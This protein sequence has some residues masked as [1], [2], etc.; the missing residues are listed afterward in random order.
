M[1]KNYLFGSLFLLYSWFG[2]TQTCDLSIIV[3]AQNLSG[4]AISQVHIYEEFQ[5]IVTL[6]NTGNTVANV[7]FSQEIDPNV[8]VLSYESQNA[9]GG[10]S[11]VTNFNFN[12]TTLTGTVASLPTNASVQVKIVMKAS[13]LLG[14]IATIAEIFPPTTATDVNTSNNQS[15]ISIDVTDLP[16]D[17]TVTNAQIIPPEGTGISNWNETVTYEFTITNN[18]SIAFP[19]NS[20]TGYLNLTSDSLYG[21][22]LVQFQSLTCV[23]ATGGVVCPD[24]SNMSSTIMGILVP[25]SIFSFNE[26]IEFPSGASIT[27]QVEYTYLEPNCALEVDTI[28]VDSY[29]QIQINHA[30]ESSNTSNLV[31]TN[32]LE[33]TL[34][35]Q[36]DLCIETTQ[37]NPPV[38]QTINWGEPVTFVTTVCNNGPLGAN[39]SFYFANASLADWNIISVT[40]DSTTGSI[41]CSDFTLTIAGNQWNS[42]EFFL[43]ENTT[44]TITTIVVFLEPE[45]CMPQLED[46]YIGIVNSE[47][48]L[49]ETTILESN[50]YNNLDSDEVLLPP[51][52]VCE[53]EDYIDLQ[54]TKTQINPP[55]PAGSSAANTINWGAVTYH[56]VASNPSNEDAIVSILDYMPNGANLLTEAELV[57]VSCIATTGTAVCPTTITSAVGAVLDGVPQDGSEDIFWQIEAIENYILPA[58]SSATFET[59][60][61]WY[62][63]CYENPILATNSAKIISVDNFPDNNPYNNVANEITYFAPCVDLLV[64]TYPEFTSVPVNQPFNWIVDITNSNT[65]SNAIN[66]DFENILAPEFTIVGNPTCQV[67]NGVANCITNFTTTGSSITGLIPNMDA[68]STI[69][70]I[71]P[72]E[73]PNFGGAFTNIAEAIP[74]PDDNEELTPETN[75]SI[76]NIQVIAPIL[77]KEFIPNQIFVNQESE[78]Q[79]TIYNSAGNPAQNN[80][81]FTDNLPT[82]ILVSG[83]PFWVQSNGCSA[84]FNATVGGTF[85]EVTN[86]SIPAGVSSCTFSIPITTN[87]L[88]NYTNE[89]SN[90]S[91]LNSIDVSLVYAELEVIEDTSIVDI[92]ILK[93]VHPTTVFLNEEVTFTITAEN[94]GEDTATNISI[95]EM[96]PSGYQ[97]ISATTSLGNYDASTSLWNIATLLPN[98]S[99]TLELT[100]Q[101]LSEA[102]LMNTAILQDLDQPDLDLTNNEASAATLVTF[103][104]VDIEI[105]KDVTPKIVAINEEVTF[106][107]TAENLGEDTATNISILEALPIGY[108]FISATTTFGTYNETN[109]LWEIP[110]LLPNQK[111][112]LTISAKVV[113]KNNVL[114]IATLSN[115]NETDVNTLNNQ[116]YAAVT[117]TNCLQIPDAFSPNSDS[118]NDFFSIPCI[119]DYT[120]AELFI[121]NR[122]GTL[123]YY[124]KGYD[125]SWDGK[126][127]QGLLY[128]KNKQVPV[129]TYFYVLKLTDV[130]KIKTGWIYVTY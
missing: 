61:N 35:P 34:C 23:S 85:F 129:G 93:V 16:I 65:S 69:Q 111:E 130:S 123:L 6:I 37:T 68:A 29:V 52:P 12:G 90:F 53:E 120:N 26:V 39:T 110:S 115:L 56:I 77:D 87:N 95:L 88:G 22:A 76:S 122:Y 66:I 79:F 86:L 5:Y 58:S 67:I 100:A 1:L 46:N 51:L 41:N 50:S 7:T 97:F 128:D 33:T 73:A 55:L 45:D 124:K 21:I 102:N 126:P 125:N 82:N 112:T 107:I 117:I 104:I 20:F 25:T 109:F 103:P 11:A 49:L 89:T 70:I 78:L 24:T 32:L 3:E 101:V 106:T 43:P 14:G 71:I 127:N 63:E 91:N 9:L 99:A 114:N 28:I 60:I 92:Q 98:Q 40:C 10:A 74:D 75:I 119:L 8:T 108:S 15:I 36:T 94:L 81:S 96:L 19:L 27:F 17:F 118:F 48:E 54:I 83:T 64:Q 38:D 42:N 84:N 80:I 4:T 2:C 30:N 57:S 31:P 116:D 18:S 105:L 13:T 47:V 113:S 59:I 121:Y 62:P 72:V 44:I